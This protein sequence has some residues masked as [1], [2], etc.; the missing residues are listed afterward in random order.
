MSFFA[1]F[2]LLKQPLHIIL[3]QRL[4]ETGFGGDDIFDE[5]T[6]LFLQFQDLFL[7]RAARDDLVNEDGRVCPMRWARSEACIST[8]GFHHGSR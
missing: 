7:H 5:G 2:I 8:A 4:E 1:K 6:F 3:R